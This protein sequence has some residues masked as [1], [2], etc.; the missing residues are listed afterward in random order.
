MPKASNSSSSGKQASPR[1]PTPTTIRPRGHDPTQTWSIHRPRRTTENGW[2]CWT[3]YEKSGR[4]GW[5][6]VSRGVGGSDPRLHRQGRRV[7]EEPG[8]ESTD[9]KWAVA[10]CTCAKPGILSLGQK[11][12]PTFLLLTT[13][14]FQHTSVTEHVTMN[15]FDVASKIIAGGIAGASET[16]IT[17]SPESWLKSSKLVEVTPLT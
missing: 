8:R 16:I 7:Q 6:Q 4:I 14:Q 1:S 3:G 12:T 15:S 17:V 10:V 13:V 9:A 11:K 2:L 5:L